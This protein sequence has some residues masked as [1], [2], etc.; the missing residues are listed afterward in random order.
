M[1]KH[2]ENDDQMCTWLEEDLR[3]SSPISCLLPSTRGRGKCAK[4][5][6]EYL[7]AK[8]N[9]F[10]QRCFEIAGMNTRFDVNCHLDTGTN[11]Q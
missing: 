1:Q 3:M 2:G 10:L 5:L 9:D 4:L 8:H 7:T 6:A 11:P